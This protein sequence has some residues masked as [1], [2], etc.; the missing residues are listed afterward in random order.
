MAELR[1][2]IN[3]EPEVV[4]PEP[5]P[6]SAK[7]PSAKKA[8]G[9]SRG[10]QAGGKVKSILEGSFLIR[11]KMIGLLPFL[12][13]LTG[14]GLLYIFNSNYANRTIITI[15]KT[16]KQIEEQRFEYINT[17][18]KLMQTTRQTEIAKRLQNSGLKESKTPPRKILIDQTN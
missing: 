15:S 13:F 18:S 17:K 2:T 14:I 6:S 12:V 7:E 10:K 11:E 16:K 5:K 4:I 3:I 1:N 9:K 8:K